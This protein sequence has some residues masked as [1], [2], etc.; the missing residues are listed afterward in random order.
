MTRAHRAAYGSAPDIWTAEAFDATR[1][2]I[3]R[4]VTAAAGGTRPT[5][6][7]L[8]TALTQGTFRGLTKEYAFDERRQVKG[9]VYFTHQVEGGRMR[10]VGPAVQP[11]PG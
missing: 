3:D 8:L 5:R 2:I 4:L 6:S 10:Y 7:A 11:A 9:N 1:L